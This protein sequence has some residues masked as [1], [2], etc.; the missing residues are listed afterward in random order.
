M[1]H[2][3][4]KV[5]PLDNMLLKVEFIDNEI[6]LYDVKKLVSKWKVF[7]ILKDKKLFNQVK[8]DQGGY[9]IIWSDEID[10]ACEE[11]WENGKKVS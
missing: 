10:I 4:R 1:F 8:V 9:G 3:I 5:E 11:L 6:K 2:R 7:E